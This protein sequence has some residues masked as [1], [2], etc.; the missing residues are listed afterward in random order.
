MWK[1]GRS[2]LNKENE[3]IRNEII[4]ILANGSTP[5]MD[6]KTKK[7]CECS[8]MDC[9]HC[10]FFSNS[11]GGKNCCEDMGNWLNLEYKEPKKYIDWNIVPIDTPILVKN[12]DMEWW[13][14][15]HF[16]G[17]YNSKVCSYIN[18]KTSWSNDSEL[19]EWNYAKLAREEDEEKYEK[20]ED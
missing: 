13:H 16:A 5:G 14:K 1:K 3:Q 12:A 20:F 8:E 7:L 6:K 19:F 11:Y 4:E 17:Y 9:T 10:A 2:M 18:G 15:R